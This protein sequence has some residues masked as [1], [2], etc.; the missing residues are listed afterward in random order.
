MTRRRKSIM[1]QW[2][3]GR[4]SQAGHRSAVNKVLTEP[5]I[6]RFVQE[7]IHPGPQII[8][9]PVPPQRH[10]IMVDVLPDKVMVCDCNGASLRH[11]RLKAWKTYRDV[12]T[13]V[14]QKFPGRPIR[15]YPV[16]GDLHAAALA[17]DHAMDGGGCSFYLF[18]WLA[19]QPQYE[20]YAV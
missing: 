15:F 3:L 17:H 20:N 2:N 11:G 12:L 13:A 5:E 16:D 18:A 14:E 4:I 6:H 8:T 7:H 9:I 1:P 19:K 10:A